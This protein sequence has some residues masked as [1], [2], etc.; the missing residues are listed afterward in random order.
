M[1]NKQPQSISSKMTKTTFEYLMF[2]YTHRFQIKAFVEGTIKL[3]KQFSQAVMS[4][5][6]SFKQPI[7]GKSETKDSSNTPKE[8][9][10]KSKEDKVNGQS[11]NNG[12]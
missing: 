12:K 9:P 3:I 6:I 1:Q 5:R 7:D 10:N 2:I 8:Q 4:V 11:N